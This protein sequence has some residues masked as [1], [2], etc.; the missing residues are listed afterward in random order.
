MNPPIWGLVAGACTLGAAADARADEPAELLPVQADFQIEVAAGSQMYTSGLYLDLSYVRVL[1]H[2][3][4]DWQLFGGLGLADDVVTYWQRDD[5]RAP[6]AIEA[7]HSPGI[8]A[9]VG[10]IH[11]TQ[12]GAPRIVVKATPMWSRA[13]DAMGL[14]GD[15]GL[16]L[17]A[18]VGLSWPAWLL[19]RIDPDPPGTKSYDQTS[20]L[21]T[22]FAA[23]IPSEVEYV[24]QHVPGDNRNGV[25]FGWCF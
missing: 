5:R 4:A 23:V 20:T 8:E 3:T 24:F 6:D 15:R 2:L 16:G 25:A 21:A 10:I 22:I 18:S 7:I 14:P 17:R 11:G 12:L 1:S 9:R 13:T 19:G